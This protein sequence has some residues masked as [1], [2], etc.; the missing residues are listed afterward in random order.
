MSPTTSTS[1]NTTSEASYPVAL[2]KAQNKP[3]ELTK[4]EVDLLEHDDLNEALANLTGPIHGRRAHP[5]EEEIIGWVNE[6]LDSMELADQQNATQDSF[7]GRLVFE[8]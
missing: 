7:F 4:A 3:L 6:A 5:K 1:T 2:H 8:P